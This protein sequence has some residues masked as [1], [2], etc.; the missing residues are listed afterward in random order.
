MLV[1]AWSLESHIIVIQYCDRA[2]RQRTRS[3][4]HTVSHVCRRSLP[5]SM[6]PCCTGTVCAST[7]PSQLHLFRVLSEGADCTIG[8]NASRNGVPV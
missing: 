8:L 6:V 2:G 5:P 4:S 7:A 3:A 1:H